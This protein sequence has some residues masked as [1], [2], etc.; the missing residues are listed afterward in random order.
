MHVVGAPGIDALVQTA[1]RSREELARDFGLDPAQPWLLAV[2]HPVT[3]EAD[4]AGEQMVETMEALV[5]LGL[6]TVLVYPNADAGSGA[7]IDVIHRYRM[8]HIRVHP[9]LPSLD[10]LSL[11]KEAAALVGNSSSG[12]IEAPS[13]GTPA[14]NIGSRQKGRERGDNVI[15]VGY[16]RHEIEAAI[17]RALEDRDFLRAVARRRNPYGDGRAAP[18]IARLLAEIP[19][20]A[21]LLRKEL[22]L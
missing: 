11:L 4:R 16:N 1:F 8:P 5:A 9:S 20:D 19:L 12:I 21:R 13:L 17:R 7:M 2:Q 22:V 15:D 18:R 14:V 10:F 3:A 6:P